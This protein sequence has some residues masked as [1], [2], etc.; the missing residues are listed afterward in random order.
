MTIYAEGNYNMLLWLKLQ[1]NSFL[2]DSDMLFYVTCFEPGMCL[3]ELHKIFL[4]LKKTV[5]I[6]VFSPKEGVFSQS[7]S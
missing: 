3:I 6:L 1:I 7:F 5:K 4:M 2:E